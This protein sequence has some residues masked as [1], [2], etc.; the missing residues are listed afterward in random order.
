MAQK[1]SNL[2]FTN[3]LNNYSNS[4]S[5]FKTTGPE[6]Y[7][8]LPSLD[9]LVLGIGSGASISGIGHYLKLE[10]PKI[11]VFGVQPLAVIR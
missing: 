8:Q 7:N 4:Y 9:A 6:I 2:Y 5:H 11:K 3:Q 10:N 1:D